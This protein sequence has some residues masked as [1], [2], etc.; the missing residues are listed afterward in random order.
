[1]SKAWRMENN[2]TYFRHCR[3]CRLLAFWIYDLQDLDCLW[4]LKRSCSNFSEL[5]ISFLCSK[6]SVS[7]PWMRLAILCLSPS[8]LF[9]IHFHCVFHFTIYYIRG[10]F[11]LNN[12]WLVKSLVQFL[13]GIR[14]Y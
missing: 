13:L 3:Y 4:P 7:S 2:E 1:M 8:L 11:M 10:H 6:P 12:W 14:V 5:L 9:S